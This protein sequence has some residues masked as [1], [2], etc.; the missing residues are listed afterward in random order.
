MENFIQI[1]V[2]DDF[3]VQLKIDNSV[4]ASRDFILT[5]VSSEGGNIG[6]LEISLSNE[7]IRINDVVLDGLILQL[8]KEFINQ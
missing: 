1:E 2:E 5:T 7:E 4:K 6:R 3:N 8:F